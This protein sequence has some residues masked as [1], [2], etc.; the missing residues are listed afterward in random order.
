MNAPFLLSDS[1]QLKPEVTLQNRLVKASTEELLA[2]SKGNITG[3]LIR[4]YE[5]WGK[6]SPGMILTGNIFVSPEA[7]CRKGNGYISEDTAFKRDFKELARAASA[8]GAKAIVQINHAGRQALKSSFGEAVGPSDIGV[9]GFGPLMK[10]PR[11]LAEPEIEAII[12]DF[13]RSAKVVEE[14]GFA[15]VQIHS[16]H[17]YL[18]SQF[19]SPLVNKRQDKWG[20]SL[21]N[22]SRLLLSIVKAVKEATSENFIVCV[23]L[24]SADFQRGGFDES[25]SMEVAKKLEELAIDFLEISGGS[26]EEPA[27]MGTAS[28][29][30]REA[31]FLKFAE[32]L[33]LKVKTKLLVTGGFRSAAGMN[34]AL[35]DGHCDLIGVARPFLVE[36]DFVKKILEEKSTIDSNTWTDRVGNRK[37]DA[38]LQSVWYKRQIRRTAKFGEPHGPRLNPYL[39]LAVELPILLWE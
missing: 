25:E 32:Q 5:A 33:R 16:A 28:T 18:L 9:K 35:V 23:K 22:R 21:E 37:L 3:D 26:Y 8:G 34:Q 24:N 30:K 4:L 7:V 36:K 6:K 1:F 10:K 15:G 29:Q 2:D 39:T 13:V 12:N 27:M 19:L 38:I 11:S 31:Y 20:G 17:G 14:C